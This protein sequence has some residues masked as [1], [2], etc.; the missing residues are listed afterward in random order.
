MLFK[1]NSLLDLLH[2][3][4][5]K[6]YGNGRRRAVEF[7]KTE[8]NE[9]IN[10]QMGEH[11]EDFEV[12]YSEMRLDGWRR[13]ETGDAIERPWNVSDHPLESRY[14]IDGTP[15]RFE[16][17]GN[18]QV[19]ANTQ[20]LFPDVSDEHWQSAA[21]YANGMS[22]LYDG[23]DIVNAVLTGTDR[24]L[25]IRTYNQTDHNDTPA[26]VFADGWERMWRGIGDLGQLKVT[27]VLSVNQSP[28]G[29][30]V[31]AADA[32]KDI[33]VAFTSNQNVLDLIGNLG[34]LSGTLGLLAAA[35]GP[36]AGLMFP[37][38][39][40]L[41][42]GVSIQPGGL[43]ATL[44]STPGSYL[45]AVTQNATYGRQGSIIRQASQTGY[46]YSQYLVSNYDDG[47]SLTKPIAGEIKR[48][49]TRREVAGTDTERVKGAE[50]M[51]QNQLVDIITGSV[52]L[53][54]TLPAT[55][56]KMHHRTADESLR[57]RFGSGVGKSI[58]VDFWFDLIEEVI[59]DDY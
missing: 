36:G 7:E 58:S 10:E 22:F 43:G 39:N 49:V 54:F 6:I 38:L 1:A 48:K 17:Y 40:G 11:G 5:A 35:F 12:R 21:I 53:N 37:A 30:L 47:K 41:S 16:N 57:V 8:Y 27:G 24:A 46:T 34:R 51:W 26:L 52:P 59:H 13:S 42:L 23:V 3:G 33:V 15:G 28:Y 20:H 14:G 25:L 32:L 2:S 31:T 18:Q 56:S 45:P 9:D 44:G 4:G 29:F 50:V 19:R 55:A